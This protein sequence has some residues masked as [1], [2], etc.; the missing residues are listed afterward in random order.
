METLLTV[1]FG[2]IDPASLQCPLIDLVYEAIVLFIVAREASEAFG[3]P[4]QRGVFCCQKFRP[5]HVAHPIIDN[6]YLWYFESV[7]ILQIDPALNGTVLRYPV[8][9]SSD[10]SNTPN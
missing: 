1:E 7:D 3:F 6:R 2:V 8:P 9:D 10:G 5:Q 4:A